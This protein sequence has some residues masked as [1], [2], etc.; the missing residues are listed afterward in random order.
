[1][2]HTFFILCKK[3]T[4]YWLHESNNS[5]IEHSF[6]TAGWPGRLQGWNLRASSG[7]L[8]KSDS[9]FLCIFFWAL[10]I[11]LQRLGNL[12]TLLKAA[13]IPLFFPAPFKK[14]NPKVR[15]QDSGG[16]LHK[17]KESYTCASPCPTQVKQNV[18]THLSLNKISSKGCSNR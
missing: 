3:K 11:S 8:L 14:P 15:T 9:F 13:I 17:M 4:S 7:A 6:N 5:R 2:S 1:M 16:K 10:V 18:M 12:K